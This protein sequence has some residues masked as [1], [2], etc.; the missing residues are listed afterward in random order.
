[1]HLPLQVLYDSVVLFQER[2]Q[3]F[4]AAKEEG[5]ERRVRLQL[6]PHRGDKPVGHHEQYGDHQDNFG[7]PEEPSEA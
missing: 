3:E 2:F 4:S 5:G 1:M 7:K 6:R